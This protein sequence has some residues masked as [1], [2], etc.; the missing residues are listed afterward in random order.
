[1][2]TIEQIIPSIEGTS[3]VH[4]DQ[5]GTVTEATAELDDTASSL[6]SG[7]D[8]SSSFDV[9]ETPPLFRSAIQDIVTTLDLLY[10]LSMAIRGPSDAEHQRLRAKKYPMLRDSE[11]NDVRKAAWGFYLDVVTRK[12]SKAGR[13]QMEYKASKVCVPE[14][15]KQASCLP[16]SLESETTASNVVRPPKPTWLHSRL[17]DTMLQR[18]EK[19]EYLMV[20]IERLAEDETENQAASQ[21][22]AQQQHEGNDRHFPN[23]PASDVTFTFRATSLPKSSQ[24]T[25]GAPNSARSRYGGTATTFSQRRFEDQM[26]RNQKAASSKP[27][28]STVASK[29]TELPQPP[30]I[31]PGSTEIQCNYCG[32]LLVVKD[33]RVKGWR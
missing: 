13:D 18:R 33:N 28:R 16:L 22:P 21:R 23:H 14:E 3:I 8:L 29:N 25:P 6:S 15:R 17:A 11:G 19:L 26:R 9:A 27:S 7:S 12:H 31:S 1:M 20:H 10:Q 5:D 30:R 4:N 32:H 24:S 2:S